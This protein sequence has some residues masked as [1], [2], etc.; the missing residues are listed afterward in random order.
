MP[1]WRF[2]NSGS[3][4]AFRF[5]PASSGDNDQQRE[6]DW[7]SSLRPLWDTIAAALYGQSPSFMAIIMNLL[8]CVTSQ[9]SG[10]RCAV[11][12]RRRWRLSTADSKIQPSTKVT[13]MFLP[14]FYSLYSFLFI[15]ISLLFC[16]GVCCC[17]YANAP[18]VEKMKAF[19][20]ILVYCNYTWCL[21]VMRTEWQFS[22]KSNKHRGFFFLY[23][24]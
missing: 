23:S 13:P 8:A 21:C 17:N 16:A 2:D 12:S 3:I 7:K 15:I 10:I 6:M 1:R 9:S 11:P 22:D 20:L 14:C 5:S 24:L 4:R 19:Y 18:N